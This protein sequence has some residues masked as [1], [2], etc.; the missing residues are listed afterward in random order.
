MAEQEDAITQ[1]I[2]RA[3]PEAGLTDRD[4]TVNEQRTSG[5]DPLPE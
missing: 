5:L 3:Y 2:E 4:H 1:H